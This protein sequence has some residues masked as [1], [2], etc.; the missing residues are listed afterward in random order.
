MKE[1]FSEVAFNAWFKNT[2]PIAFDPDTKEMTVTVESAI[3][4]GYWE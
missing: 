3:S 4:K 1:N 2:K